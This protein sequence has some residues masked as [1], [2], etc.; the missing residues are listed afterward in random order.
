MELC[1]EHALGQRMTLR[2][3]SETL[4][5]LSMKA[6]KNS[7]LRAS[8]HVFIL[9]RGGFAQYIVYLESFHEKNTGN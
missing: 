6:T 1:P 9:T 4:E 3:I 5:E 8:E 7:P 2:K